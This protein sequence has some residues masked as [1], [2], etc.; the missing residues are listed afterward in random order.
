MNGRATWIVAVITSL[1]GVGAPVVA[2]GKR[3]PGASTVPQ[4]G[5][6]DDPADVGESLETMDPPTIAFPP[7][8]RARL[9]FTIGRGTS[10]CGGPGLNPPPDPPFSGEVDYPDGSKRADLG[11]GCQYSGGGSPTT[12]VAGFAVPD[13]G[14]SVTAVTAISG[15][16]VIIGPDPGTGPAD[17]TLGG[18]P[19]RHCVNGTGAEACRTDSGCPNGTTGSCDLD[20][21]CFFG[22]P[23][24]LTTSGVGI[25]VV[26]AV[27]D[28]VEG[29][30]DLQTGT[31]TTSTALSSRLYLT[32]NR[33]SPCPQ[34]VSGTC[35][36][37]E[38]AGLPCSGGVGSRNTTI[39]CPPKLSG[40]LGRL[41]I[42]LAGLTTGTATASDPDGNFCP[43]QAH[44]G[45][46]GGE[47]GTIR[48]TGSPA[49]RDLSNPFETT[50]AGTF[51]VPS[52]GNPV[53]DGG[54]DLPGPGALSVR[55][56]TTVILPLP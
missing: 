16:T 2:S 48:E 35:T 40:F 12:P 20:A 46:F 23:V 31:S 53:I 56:T 47:A 55:G 15:S 8:E 21:N 42:A 54:G 34:C 43:G 38:R 52:S 22:P 6:S 10:N 37:G 19:G 36:Y 24:P 28:D 49:G 25:C 39:E 9:R 18:G 1:L 7:P 26:S 13:G 41:T 50:I 3:L 17:C 29:S 30:A 27:R 5:G 11:L 44:P 32:G 33:A 51:C 45:A 14:T 4:V